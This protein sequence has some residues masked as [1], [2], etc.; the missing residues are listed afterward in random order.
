LIDNSD[1]PDDPNF[2]PFRALNKLRDQIREHAAQHGLTEVQSMVSLAAE[3][4][5][6]HSVFILDEDWSAPIDDGFDEVMQ[7]AAQA[8]HDAQQAQ[9][10]EESRLQM[11]QLRQEL[12]DP[13]KGLGFD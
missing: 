12:E 6:F 7:G 13:S 2:N 1:N 4:G 11:Q 3:S 10:V 5:R 9:R 8:E